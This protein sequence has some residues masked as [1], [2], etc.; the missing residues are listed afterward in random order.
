[1]EKNSRNAFLSGPK[2]HFSEKNILGLG[3]LQKAKC[4]ADLLQGSTP[5][6]LSVNYIL[7]ITDLSS[8]PIPNYK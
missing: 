1:M 7:L 2:I 3:A 6:N 4:R 5:M 8:K